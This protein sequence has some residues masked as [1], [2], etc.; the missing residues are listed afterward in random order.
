MFQNGARQLKF[1]T[2]MMYAYD[3][4]HKNEREYLLNYYRCQIQQ[5]CQCFDLKVRIS[6]FTYWQNLFFFWENLRSHALSICLAIWYAGALRSQKS[7]QDLFVFPVIF[8]SLTFI[9]LIR[10][11]FAVWRICSDYRH[12]TASFNLSFIFIICN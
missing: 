2:A 4:C 12:V 5:Q 10:V 7:P 11:A 1:N 9:N 3:Q 8:C 6:M